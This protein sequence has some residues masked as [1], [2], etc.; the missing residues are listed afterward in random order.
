MKKLHCYIATIFVAFAAF[1]CQT[2]EKAKTKSTEGINEQTALPRIAFAGI[3]IESSTFSPAQTHEESFHVKIGDEIFS[4]Y[5]FMEA[6]ESLRERANWFP[7]LSGKSV[8]G[9]IVTR[10]SY[11]S[12]VGKTLTMLKENL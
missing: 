6:G 4:K 8:P 2:P 11:E 3:A 12:M 1:G 9:G 5:R 10:E 7:T